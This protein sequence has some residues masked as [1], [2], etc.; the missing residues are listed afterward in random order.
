MKPLALNDS[1]FVKHP[2][3]TRKAQF[4]REMGQVVPWSQLVALVEPY[5]PRPGKGR[6]PMLLEMMLRTYFMQ[7]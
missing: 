6:L 7:Q 4:L 3:E 1:G 5:H 2:K